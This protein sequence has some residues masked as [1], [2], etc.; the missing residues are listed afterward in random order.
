MIKA[1]CEGSERRLL[2]LCYFA[3]GHRATPK[4]PTEILSFISDLNFNRELLI[5]EA[6]AAQWL[7]Q[8][9]SS[10]IVIHCLAGTTRSATII[11]LDI[12]LKK[13]DDT[14]ARSCGPM[15][16]VDDVVLRLRNQRAMAIQKPEQYLFL[17]LAVFEHAVRQRYI[18]ENT[19]NE[20]DLENY[21]YNPQRPGSGSKD[22]EDTGRKSS[23][24]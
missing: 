10:P 9:E 8:N 16:D 22:Q 24:T 20:I 5:K 1:S 7:K 14:A 15:V 17:H 18:S 11:A 2:H 19:Y 6:V 4:K 21:F 13:L 3:W 12:S 23:S